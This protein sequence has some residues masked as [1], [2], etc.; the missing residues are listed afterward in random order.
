[1]AYLLPLSK[2][3]AP[4]SK[5]LVHKAWVAGVATLSLGVSACEGPKRDGQDFQRL[6]AQ[7]QSI[8]VD[9]T[10]PAPAAKTDPAAAPVLAQAEITGPRDDKAINVI[11]DTARDMAVGQGGLFTQYNNLKV[12]IVDPLELDRNQPP[13]GVVLSEAEPEEA[14]S[15]EKV[16]AP[17]MAFAD[18]NLSAVLTEREVKP[19]SQTVNTGRTIQIG[20]FSTRQGAQ[21]AW[22]KLT[23]V[24]PEIARFNPQMQNVRTNGGKV[25]VRLKVGPVYTDAEAQVLCAKLEVKDSWCTRA[26]G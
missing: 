24:H 5:G 9:E 14:S 17:A 25:L 15:V 10:S 22:D 3:L 23:T 20:S 7:I 26:A 4:L 21:A 12:Q 2:D 16:V 13:K 6:A 1:M 19:A 8:Q 18:A 11:V